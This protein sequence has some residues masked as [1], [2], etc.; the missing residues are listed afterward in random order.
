M[1]NNEIYNF[2]K[3]FPIFKDLNEYEMEPI[4]DFARSRK[5]ESG[6]IVFMQHE[7]L[8][9]VYFIQSGKVKIYKTDYEGKEQIVNVLQKD[10][11]FP[12][13]GFF[14]KGNYP[15]HAEILEDALLINIPILSFENFLL[16][17]PEISIKMFRVLSEIIIDLQKRLEE[18]ILYNVY[19]Q[20]ILLLLR[21]A[22]KNGEQIDEN[23]SKLTVL[24]TNRELANMI[25]SSRETI[26]RTLTQ[27]KKE[28]VIKNDKNGYLIVNHTELE[29]K[30]FT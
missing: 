30:V 10:D 6:T 29:E 9:D 14:R 3:Q 21:L 7:P 11:M 20:I 19:D 25:G 1:K 17:H 18:K 4:V 27:L 5:Y 26:S 15:A 24:L 23:W 2:L 13:Q 22:K 12:H 8:T 28:H 16:T